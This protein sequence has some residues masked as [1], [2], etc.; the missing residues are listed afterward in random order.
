MPRHSDNWEL[1]SDVRDAPSHRVGEDP[2]AR[3][4]RAEVLS[5][6]A[7]VIPFTGR[8]REMTAALAHLLPSEL[9]LL[10][11]G[12]ALVV[13]GD[14]GTGKTFFARELMRRA[15]RARPDALF[16]Y[17]D[18]ANDEYQGARTVGGILRLALVAGGMIGSS[19]ISVPAGLSLNR[20]R[21]QTGRRGAGRN[22][23]RALVRVSRRLSA[24]GRSQRSPSNWRATS[25]GFRSRTSSPPT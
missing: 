17:I 14:S 19:T 8:E 2:Q 22:F 16:L 3:A 11:Q 13:H 23:F 7:L 1:S 10:R 21:R 25:M 6:R 24:S 12:R 5:T 9:G 4:V 15:H 20:Y 18:V